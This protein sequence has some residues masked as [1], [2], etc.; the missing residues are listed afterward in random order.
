MTRPRILRLLVVCPSW[1]GDVVMA[2]PALRLIRSELPGAFIGGLVRPGLDELLAGS[3][4]LDEMHVDRA[5]GVMG[6]KHVAGRIRPRRYDTA[7]LLS[8]SFSAALIARLAFIPRRVGYDRDA[9]G[10]LLTDR[11]A[12][13]RRG[14][15]GTGGFCPVSAVDYYLRAARATLGDLA[16]PVPA[17]LELGATSEQE[18][19]GAEVLARAGVGAGQKYA[20]LNPGG[21]NPAKRWPAERFVAV[22]RHVWETRGWA[23]LVNGAPGEQELCAQIAAG[24]AAGGGRGAS[25]VDA[26]VTLGALKPIVRGAG[27]MVTNDTGPRHIAAAM[28]TPVV[29]LFGPTDPRWTSLPPGGGPV[30]ELVANPE[31][32]KDQVADEHP[33]ACRIERIGVGAVIAGVE[34]ALSPGA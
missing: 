24:I 13:E 16:Q 33:E 18:R 11:L 23:V 28:G 27:V 19:S 7:V 34:R 15:L 32:P 31:L 29:T 8:N 17:R 10:L 30:V 4:L 21:N 22:G 20:V 1:V 9:R 12:P 3:G 5:V 25:L 6:P 14:V 2:T 26:G